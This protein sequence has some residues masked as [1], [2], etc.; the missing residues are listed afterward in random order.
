VQDYDAGKPM[1]IE[2]QLMTPLAFA[3]AAEVPTPTLD[4][5]ARLSAFKAVAKGLYSVQSLPVQ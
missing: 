4:A 2:S 5:L 1:E 3:R